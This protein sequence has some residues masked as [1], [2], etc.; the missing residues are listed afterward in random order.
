MEDNMDFKR[1]DKRYEKIKQG[2]LEAE[3]AIKARI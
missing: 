3:E 1:L 2:L